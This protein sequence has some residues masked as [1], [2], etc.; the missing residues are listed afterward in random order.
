M[1]P[2][3]IYAEINLD[4]ICQNV[5]NAMA[6]VGDARVMAIVKADAYGHGAVPVAK[7]LSKIGV[8]GFG[9]ATAKEALQLRRAGIENL[10]LILG[11]VFEDDLAELIKQDIS[12]TVFSLDAAQEIS[13]AATALHKNAKIHIKVDTGMGRI[14]MQPDESS[15]SLLKEILALPHIEPQGIFTHFACAD[16]MD[17]TSCLRQKEKFLHFIDMANAEG[18][19][20]QIRHMCNSAAIIDFED[21]FLDMVRCGIM[22][23]GLYPSDEVKKENLS[24]VPAMQIKSH[25]S[26]VK[27]VGPDF[28]VSYGSTYKTDKDT[29]I[30]TV[31]VGYADG[32]PRALS[33]KGYVLIH[34]QKAQILGRVCMDQMMLDVTDI[35]NVKRGDQVVLIGRDGDETITMEDVANLAGSFNYELS[36]SISKRVPHVYEEGNHVLEVLDALD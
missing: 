18:I 23:Y 19:H 7:E 11:P 13:K 10:I 27:K 8:F 31:P 33:N 1:L 20:F 5:K 15:L 21:D 35:P 2:Q 16:E 9:V 25:V 17:K 30:A 34:G 6:K 36:C 24:L 14:G 29:V 4:T 12:L 3:R 22:T 28:A 32:Y 26:F